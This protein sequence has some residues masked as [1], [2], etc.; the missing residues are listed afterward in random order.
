MEVRWLFASGQQAGL[1]DWCPDIAIA[2]MAYIV[3]EGDLL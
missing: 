3:V 2:T 1:L